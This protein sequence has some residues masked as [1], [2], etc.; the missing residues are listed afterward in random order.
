MILH[1]PENQKK[2]LN[3][4]IKTIAQRIAPSEAM[5]SQA[6]STYTAVTNA[7]NRSD[8][9]KLLHPKL[10][11]QGSMRLGTCIRSHKH[12]NSFD[13]D[14]IV[15][16]RY[17]PAS[18]TQ[19]DVKEAVLEA[20]LSDPIYGKMLK[21]Q[22]GGRRCV[23]IVYA[24]GSHVDLLPCA[25]SELYI[26]SLNARS[27]TPEN[28][29]LAITDRKHWG[30]A[31]ETDKNFWP[32]SNPIGYADWFLQIA[33]KNEF[34]HKGASALLIRA[35]VETF[36]R[37]QRPE[38][39]NI[40]QQI[41]MLL[42]RHRD[43]MFDG[44]DDMPVSILLTTLAAL[45]Y[46]NAPV[47]DLWET[48]C[49]VAEHMTDFIQYR[50][51]KPIV[52]NPVNPNED[53]ADKWPEK[54]QKQEFFFKW[55]NQLRSDINDIIRLDGDAYKNRLKLMFGEIA[56]AGARSIEG[57]NVHER[58]KAGTL[59]I[60]AT[61]GMITSAAN[62]IPSPMHTNLAGRHQT[63]FPM[64]S[65]ISIS[66]QMRSLKTKYP[67]SYGDINK[68]TARWIFTVRPTPKSQE[69]KIRVKFRLREYPTVE[70]LNP[71]NLLREKEGSDFIH[72]FRDSKRGHQMLCLFAKGDWTSQK[73]ISETIVPWAAEWCY[74]YEVWLDTGE[75][76]GGGYHKGEYRP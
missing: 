62:R 1:T 75:W 10:R 61:T 46:D 50:D 70:I 47:G 4:V 23:T 76:H 20:I 45:A 3:L 67:E 36:P 53:F 72:M 52:V 12:D 5:F 28:Y 74:F 59:G 58:L 33:R 34:K 71:N 27:V 64:T 54:P 51:G 24:D 38:N 19:K 65:A 8:R 9:L 31:T 43:M 37:Y 11:A 13:V 56:T 16:L 68:D 25:I 29:V 26:Q 69:Y 22:N 7:L 73:Y 17:V 41:V 55:I 63:V 57:R 48:F 40:L 14:I 32:Q 21:D 66:S 49:N 6:E 44:H 60:S 42:K 18:W 2:Y 39:K 35:E 30:Y 15:E